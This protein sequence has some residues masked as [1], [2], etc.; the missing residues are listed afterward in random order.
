MNSFVRISL[1]IPAYNEEALLPRLLDTIDIARDR[2]R[3]G[4]NAIEVIVGDNASTD[5][6][7]AIGED[8]GCTVA[9]IEERRIAAARNGGAL[10]ARGDILAFVDADTRIHQETFNAIEDS[11][12][13]GKVVAGATG[14]RLERM[15]LGIAATFAVFLPLVWALQMDTGVV[16]C[17]R[18]DFEA[19]GGYDERR[20]FGEDVQLLFDLRRVG[21]P[22]EQRLVRLR[23]YKAIASCRKFDLHGDWHYFTDLFRLAPLMLH[24]PGATSRFAERY[25]YGDQR[26]PEKKE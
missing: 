3:Y 8:R 22:R 2:Y 10:L 16:F 6:T 12:A 13:T 15:S 21:R 9:H 14:V 18:E 19:I 7:A 17:R 5:R 11:L 25:W 26:L 4:E 20:F 24:S 23:P 1:I